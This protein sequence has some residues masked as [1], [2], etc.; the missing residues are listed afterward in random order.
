MLHSAYVTQEDLPAMVSL[1]LPLRPQSNARFFLK[2]RVFERRTTRRVNL[3]N[4]TIQ[5]A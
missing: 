1:R 2:R 5:N 3:S 4:S